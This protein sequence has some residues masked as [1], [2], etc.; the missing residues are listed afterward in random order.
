[1]AK[2]NT[3]ERQG[4]FT[5]TPKEAK[6]RRLLREALELANEID[7]C[8]H[9]YR[10]SQGKPDGTKTLE[11]HD[12]RWRLGTWG[13]IQEALL[14]D[15]LETLEGIEAFCSDGEWSHHRCASLTSEW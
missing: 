13:A 7:R 11:S 6:L 1:M 3:R 5:H 15:G 4:E 9:Q 10:G 14:A 8:A 12:G 2:L